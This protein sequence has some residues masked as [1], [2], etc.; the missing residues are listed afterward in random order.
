MKFGNAWPDLIDHSD[1][2]MAEDAA[3]G[4]GW[5][6]AFE[7]VQIGTADRRF[8]DFDDGVGGLGD[9][10]HRPAFERLLSRSLVNKSFHGRAFFVK[11]IAVSLLGDL[12]G[13]L[14]GA[15]SEGPAQKNRTL[16][17]SNDICA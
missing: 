17:G 8:D 9:L 14:K 10:R 4:T 3:R 5:H 6:V 11:L 15:V 12:F 1:A 2:L 16:I 13:C 7:D